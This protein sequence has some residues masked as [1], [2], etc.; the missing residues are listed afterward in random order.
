MGNTL[1]SKEAIS[2]TGT[3]ISAGWQLQSQKL[4]A[5][6]LMISENISFL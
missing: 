1:Q 4:S 3:G 2:G 5:M 6:N